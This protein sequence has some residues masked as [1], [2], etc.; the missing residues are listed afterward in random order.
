MNSTKVATPSNP[1]RL[2]SRDGKHV[3]GANSKGVL[4][5]SKPVYWGVSDAR[6]LSRR[7]PELLRFID[8][9]MHSDMTTELRAKTIARVCT[10]VEMGLPKQPQRSHLRMGYKTEAGMCHALLKGRL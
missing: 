2:K 10:G 5:G 7:Q 1:I 4:F 9:G 3:N 8:K 6:I